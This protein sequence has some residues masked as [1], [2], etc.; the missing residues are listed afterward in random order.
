MHE[1]VTKVGCSVGGDICFVLYCFVLVPSEGFTAMVANEGLEKARAYFKP[2][3]PSNPNISIS[4]STTMDNIV[5]IATTNTRV[6][7]DQ[8]LHDGFVVAILKKQ[9]WSC[10]TINF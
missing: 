4:L 2:G 10:A 1:E 6:W 9:H 5:S 8:N 7:Q 3:P